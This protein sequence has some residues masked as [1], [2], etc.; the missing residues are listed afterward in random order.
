EN[1]LLLILE[2][3][4]CLTTQGG[5]RICQTYKNKVHFATIDDWYIE[6]QVSLSSNTTEEAK[7]RQAVSKD[8]TAVDATRYDR[9]HLSPCMH[10]NNDDSRTA[11]FTLTNIV[12]QRTILNQGQW[13]H[14]ETEIMQQ[15]VN[16]CYR[17]YVIVGV[18][19]GKSKINNRV[20]VPSH[21]WTAACCV[22][23]SNNP[24]NFLGYIIKVLSIDCKNE[25]S[26]KN[27]S[28]I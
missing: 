8:Y 24:I 6:P 15:F 18:I 19:R 20:N 9:G 22:N 26:N 16:G 12:P 1:M 27:N 14:Y 4:M 5:A 3:L 21:L 25:Y 11:T 23:D 28:V 7:D 13:N 2:T 10:H 17:T